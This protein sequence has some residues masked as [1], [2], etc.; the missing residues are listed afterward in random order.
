MEATRE[1]AQSLAQVNR[2]ILWDVPDHKNDL[3][4][5]CKQI[6]ALA[7]TCFCDHCQSF[8][9]GDGTLSKSVGGTG[10]AYHVKQC[11]TKLV[12]LQVRT[13]LQMERRQ[14]DLVVETCMDQGQTGLV[15]TGLF[16]C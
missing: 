7:V 8:P 10:H 5:S 4:T 3:W 9:L 13:R 11:A 14:S 16:R 12:L 15:C 6:P 1:Y 2:S